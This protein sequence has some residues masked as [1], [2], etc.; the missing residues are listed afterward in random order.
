[1]VQPL[2]Q[3]YQLRVILV[4]ARSAIWRSFLI[5]DSASLSKLHETL[6]IVMGWTNSHLHQF[7]LKGQSYGEP[8]GETDLIDER[9]VRVRDLLKRRSDALMYEYDFG[10]GWEHVVIVEKIL[11]FTTRTRLPQCIKAKGACPPEDVGGVHGY[12]RFLAALKNPKHREH[13]T[14]SEWI[15]G[16]FDEHAYNIQQVNAQLRR[17]DAQQRVPADG[18]R[19]TRSARR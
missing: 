15:G 6:Q 11:P 18:P 14:Y 3:I 17:A 13:R 9:K 2:K 7:V 19:A 8:D 10:D 12:R 1:M 4:G 16:H 5:A